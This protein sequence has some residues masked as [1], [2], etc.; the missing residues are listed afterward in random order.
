MNTGSS[1]LLIRNQRLATRSCT[2]MHT[3][4]HTHTHTR[5]QSH[6]HTYIV[7]LTH[8]HT[9]THT[10]SHPHS[11]THTVMHTHTHTH[12]H[13]HNNKKRKKT[14]KTNIKKDANDKT[15]NKLLLFHIL[16]SDLSP[17]IFSS[18]LLLQVLQC[19]NYVKQTNVYIHTH[20]VYYTH[21]LSRVSM[22]S[23]FC[24]LL[25]N[26][27]FC[28]VHVRLML[29]VGD[30]QIFFFHITFVIKNIVSI[31]IQCI[32]VKIEDGT[33]SATAGFAGLVATILLCN[34]KE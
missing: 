3:H 20:T 24:T 16:L 14:R 15:N 2:H 13:T 4:T 1:K 23:W 17:N 12:T 18:R 5:T 27:L 8:T 32:W 25:S 33:A 30:I 28:I 19:D 34:Y 21:P 10:E 11:L 29:H 22:F 26:L 31:C 7:T 9:H 6:T